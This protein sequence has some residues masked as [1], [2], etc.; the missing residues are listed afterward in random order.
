MYTNH[1]GV[2]CKSCAR[3]AGKRGNGEFVHTDSALLQPGPGSGR[4]PRRIWGTV[5][6]GVPPTL[7]ASAG[8]PFPRS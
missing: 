7:A 2:E 6:D 4:A 3:S 8:V 1:Q 5:M